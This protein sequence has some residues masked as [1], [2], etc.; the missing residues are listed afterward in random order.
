MGVRSG[1]ATARSVRR[2]FAELNSEKS[3]P[4]F[5]PALGGRGSVSLV[6]TVGLGQFHVNLIL[7]HGLGSST[8]LGIGKWTQFP[9]R[10]VDPGSDMGHS[11]LRGLASSHSFMC[12]TLVFV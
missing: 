4:S 11:G 5:E 7:Q 9:V 2:R 12:L 1:G 3:F 8:I 10:V 6:S